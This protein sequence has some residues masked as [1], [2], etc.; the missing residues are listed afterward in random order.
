MQYV[1]NIT[2]YF[3][4][5]AWWGMVTRETLR[6]DV[7]AGFI[8][9]II[10]L[11]Q[12]IAF[13]LIAGLPPQYGLYAAMVP[14]LV[15]ALWGSSR[16]LVSGPTTAIS[17]VVCASLTPLAAPGSAAYISY[18]ITLAF[19]VGVLQ[20]TLGVLRFGT[21]VRL[22]SPTVVAGF[23][24]GAGVLIAANQLKHALGIAVPQGSS[25]IETLAFVGAHARTVNGYALAVAGSTLAVGVLVRRYAPRVPYMLP[26]LGAGCLVAY[27]LHAAYGQGIGLA[28]VAELPASLPPLSLPALDLS[29]VR[30]LADAALAITLLGLTEAVAIA[31]SLG[32]RTGQH[33]DG[34][35]EF[36]GQGLSNVVGSFFSSY[37]SSGSFNRSGLNVEA[38]AQTPLAAVCAA[39]VLAG[40]TLLLAPLATYIPLAGMAAI[41]FLVAYG[42][43]D[44]KHIRAIV[45]D[46]RTEAAVLGATFLATLFVELE[47][48]IF[49]GVFLSLALF[50][51]RVMGAD[52]TEV[53]ESRSYHT[54]CAIGR[55]GNDGERYPGTLIVRIDM[56]L[57]YMNCDVVRERILRLI[58]GR[59]H[60]DATP[61]S[62]LVLHCSGVNYVD[63]A[64]LD[65]LEQLVD[66]L[67]HRGVRVGVIHVKHRVREQFTHRNLWSRLAVYHTVSDIRGASGAPTPA[68]ASTTPRNERALG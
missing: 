27:G 22:I 4:F 16:H 57:V 59:G 46:D 21:L 11:P 29:M 12:G 40:I 62:H 58:G 41:L 28:M 63:T 31:R 35:Q 55:E 34:N 42:I 43:I 26:A 47:F 37:P 10:V 36:I 50:V 15:A 1:Q 48:A 9:A 5:T 25:F 66:D 8:G 23:T 18:A 17:L 14:A 39:I 60:E 67:A 7:A 68:Y 13:A 24:A 61:V 64:G 2:A 65:M 45:R 54:L 33:I 44:Q 52:V 53:G 32:V 19:L 3:P 6:R 51:R 38:G 49:I 56:S 20:L 30:Q